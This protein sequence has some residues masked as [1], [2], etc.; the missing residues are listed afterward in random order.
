MEMTSVT[1]QGEGN[2]SK[3]YARTG[4]NMLTYL[5]L[6]SNHM[7]SRFHYFYLT[8]RKPQHRMLSK[9]SNVTQL[10]RARTRPNE[11]SGLAFT[12]NHM[13]RGH[14]AAGSLGKSDSFRL[15]GPLMATWSK[16]KI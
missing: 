8:T 13:N 2:V 3:L 12:Q 14:S 16:D 5:I 6:N 4:P 7:R 11:S 10:G 9:L 1:Q 15:S